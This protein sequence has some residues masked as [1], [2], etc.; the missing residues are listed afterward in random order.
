MD[1]FGQYVWECVNVDSLEYQ[2]VWGI[3]YETHHIPTKL[4]HFC[5]EIII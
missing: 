5:E 4:E 3:L 1:D 2:E